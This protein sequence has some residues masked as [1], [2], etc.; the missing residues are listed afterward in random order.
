[1]GLRVIV[2]GATGMI[3]KGVLLEALDD[4]G[5][6][7]VLSVVRG[8]S[9]MSHPKLE[10]VVH[11]DFFDFSSI[12]ARLRGFDACFFCLGVSAL[13]MSETEY[14]RI[15]YDVTLAAATTL[16]QLNPNLVF[17]YVSGQG[18]DSTEKGR[19]MWA[20]VKGRTENRLLDL[21]PSAYMFRPGFVRPRR[22][23]KSRVRWY[24][25]VYAVLKPF[26]ALMERT[27]PKQVTNTQ[28]IGKAM[29][30]V[31]KTKPRMRIVDPKDINELAAAYG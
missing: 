15:T 27:M 5:T 23:V 1:M 24:R 25:V 12:A 17:T 22:G 4:P 26:G 9:G 19:Q 13:G 7:K 14:S 10:E 28:K 21:F 18:T 30:Q 3:G 2:F 31:A 20:R 8:P 16:R 29:L 6:E 11:D